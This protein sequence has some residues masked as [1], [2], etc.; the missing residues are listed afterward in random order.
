MA[1]TQNWKNKTAVA[2]TPIP[3]TAVFIFSCAG[4]W[5]GCFWCSGI[6]TVSFSISS[7]HPAAAR[8]LPRRCAC[9]RAA[10]LSAQAICGF[11]RCLARHD[12]IRSFI[13][14]PLN[15]LWYTESNIYQPSKAVVMPETK[16]TVRQK[17]YKPYHGMLLTFKEKEVFH[18]KR[19]HLCFYK[20][21][22]FKSY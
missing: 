22:L 4:S 7:V 11:K 14:A 2:G 6:L 5:K 9:R 10:F 16:I 8:L 17:L 13:I 3:T 21:I 1:H 15:P 20:S 19:R 12:A 18:D